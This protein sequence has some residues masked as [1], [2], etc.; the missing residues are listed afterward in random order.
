MHGRFSALVK[1]CID[2]FESCYHHIGA[3]RARGVECA[4]LS[5]LILFDVNKLTRLFDKNWIL[6]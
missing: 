2:I 4:S 5:N 3:N 6:C 1:Y